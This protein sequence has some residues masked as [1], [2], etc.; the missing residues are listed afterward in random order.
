MADGSSLVLSALLCNSYW[1]PVR[2]AGY[3][4]CDL[5][6][7]IGEPQGCVL[8][9]HHFKLCRNKNKCTVADTAAIGL[10]ISRAVYGL[11]PTTKKK[12]CAV[13]ENKCSECLVTRSTDN[14]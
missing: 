1:T 13:W 11:K 8:G 4:V 2:T 5:V 10:K 14:Q 9:P 6:L 3:T 7:S 12:R